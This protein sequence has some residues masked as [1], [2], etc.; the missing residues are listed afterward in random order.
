MRSE[1]ISDLPAHSYC[2]VSCDDKQ[3]IIP[4]SKFLCIKGEDTVLKDQTSLEI[5]CVK[6]E[7]LILFFSFGRKQNSICR[8]RMF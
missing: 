7:D 1:T 2:E 6:N 5:E 4:K 3:T 8:G